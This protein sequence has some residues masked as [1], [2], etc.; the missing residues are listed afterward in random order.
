MVQASR[1]S[2]IFVMLAAVVRIYS[3]LTNGVGIMRLDNICAAAGQHARSTTARRRVLTNGAISRFRDFAISRFR[4]F[5][6]SGMRDSAVSRFR[7]FAISQFRDFA[8]PRF[9]PVSGEAVSRGYP[10]CSIEA[11]RQ[12]SAAF[13]TSAPRQIAEPPYAQRGVPFGLRAHP[14]DFE[15][16]RIAANSCEWLQISDFRAGA[17]LCPSPAGPLSRNLLHSVA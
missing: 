12:R 3:A 10:R 5:A 7:N 16:L 11:H 4:G 14:F 13:A 17:A 15:Y 8:I 2:V 6:I 1:L 9:H